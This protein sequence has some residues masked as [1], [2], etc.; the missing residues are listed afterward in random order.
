MPR[1]PSINWKGDQILHFLWI[2]LF[3]ILFVIWI[4]GTDG[5]GDKWRCSSS[6]PRDAS[7]LS[8][9]RCMVTT[10]KSQVL[11]HWSITSS[12]PL[13]PHQLIP[14]KGEGQ[15]I[16]EWRDLLQISRLSLWLFYI[17]FF[18]NHNSDF[19]HLKY[20]LHSFKIDSHGLYKKRYWVNWVV[21]MADH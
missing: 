5:C 18:L 14:L 16:V 3:C 15:W 8:L 4:L 20:V 6:C 1:F 13:G 12:S 2:V 21:L 17:L 19:E 7:G 10:E 11:H 9:F